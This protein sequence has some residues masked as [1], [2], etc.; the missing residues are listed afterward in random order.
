MDGTPRKMVAVNDT[1]QSHYEQKYRSEAHGHTVRNIKPTPRPLDR[2][3]AAVS[4]IPRY[5]KGGC[6]LELGAGDGAVAKALL[7]ADLGIQTYDLGDISLARVNG[8]RENLADT[9]V[10][11]RQLDAENLDGEEA[12][13]YDAIIMIALIEHFVDPLAAMIGIQRLLKPNGFVYIDTPNIA[14]YTRRAQLLLGASHP[15]RLRTR[16]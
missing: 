8:V 15:L 2:F 13:R 14:K 3:E 9:R 12:N 1:L 7:G 5:L 4:T 11:V 10:R 6:V 16:G